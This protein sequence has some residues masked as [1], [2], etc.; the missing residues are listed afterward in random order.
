[1]TVSR[2]LAGILLTAVVLVAG[3]VQQEAGKTSP[4]QIDDQKS[5]G[6]QI[7]E[8]N[9]NSGFDIPANEDAPGWKQTSGPLGGTVIRM[10]PHNGT[11]WASLYS[12]GIYELQADDSWKQ[13]AIGHGI[14]EVRAFDI[15]TVPGNENIAYVPEMIACV[16]KTIDKGASWQGLC[17]RITRD[18]ESPNFNSHTLLLDPADPKILYVP[19]HTHDQTSMLIVSADGGEQWEKR[20]IFGKHYDFNH[21]FF[22]NSQMYLA[23]AN[24]GVFVSS[25][26]GKSWTPFNRGLSDLKT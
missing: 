2:V 22:F 17:D 7:T 8:E 1:M 5:S 16:A 4:I 25:D 13:I 9:N 20:F 6:G 12:G 11:V 23:T 3:C 18:V 24:D 10:V 14:P 19:G 26:A 21:I 15:A